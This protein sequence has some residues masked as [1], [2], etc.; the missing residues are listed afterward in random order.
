[1]RQTL[2]GDLGDSQ[3]TDLSAKTIQ[4]IRL[5]GVTAAVNALAIVRAKLAAARRDAA[6]A[7]ASVRRDAALC[8]HIAGHLLMM[9][10]E[11]AFTVH[12]VAHAPRGPLSD[13]SILA[14]AFSFL[15]HA[16]TAEPA[17]YLLE[18][19]FALGARTPSFSTLRWRGVDVPHILAGLGPSSLMPL[20]SALA[21]LTFNADVQEPTRTQCARSMLAYCR[22]SASHWGERIALRRAADDANAH[23]I[24][25]EEISTALGSLADGEQAGGERLQPRYVPSLSPELDENLHE[26]LVAGDGLLTYRLLQLATLPAPAGRAAAVLGRFD[27][28]GDRIE[29]ILLGGG[30]GGAAHGHAHGHAHGGAD[31]AD[32]G[33]EA[34]EG[35]GDSDDEDEGDEPDVEEEAFG[36][37]FEGSDGADPD[38]V[39]ATDDAGD[40]DVP[41]PLESRSAASPDVRATRAESSS[42]RAAAPAPASSYAS[43]S[44]PSRVSVPVTR[45]EVMT[46]TMAELQAQLVPPLDGCVTL[47]QPTQVLLAERLAALRTK[48]KAAPTSASAVPSNSDTYLPS[49][50]LGPLIRGSSFSLARDPGPLAAPRYV[51]ALSEPRDPAPAIL[52]PVHSLHLGIM[53]DSLDVNAVPAA[54]DELV[55][56]TDA[57]GTGTAEALLLARQ[58]AA[59]DAGPSLADAP[60]YALAGLRLGAAA[61]SD[62]GLVNRLSG[63]GVTMAPPF[64]ST[65][66]PA[67]PLDASRMLQL[68]QLVIERATGSSIGGPPIPAEVDAAMWAFS[69]SAVRAT[70]AGDVA[71]RPRFSWSHYDLP[72]CCYDVVA[73]RSVLVFEGDGDDASSAGLERAKAVPVAGAPA[74]RLPSCDSRARV[75][76]S[77]PRAPLQSSPPAIFTESDVAV[78]GG[79]AVRS[80][81][82]HSVTFSRTAA[83]ADAESAPAAAGLPP[84]QLL[85]DFPIVPSTARV[86]LVL[87]RLSSTQPN[88]VF[89]AST[90]LGGARRRQLQDYIAGC[91][92]LPGFARLVHGVDWLYDPGTSPP[93]RIHGPTCECRPET[94]NLI[95][96]LRAV[97]ALLDRECESLVQRWLPRRRLLTSAELQQ[98]Y[99]MH[100]PPGSVFAAADGRIFVDESALLL[101]G[102]RPSLYRPQ[103]TAVADTRAR[104]A[105]AANVWASVGVASSS[106][107]AV[108]DPAAMQSKPSHPQPS[109]RRVVIVD[110]VLCGRNAANVKPL[111]VEDIDSDDDGSSP[112][113]HGGDAHPTARTAGARP[114]APLS[115]AAMPACLARTAA[116]L[117]E[118][119]CDSAC[120]AG[121]Q[122][123]TRTL[124]RAAAAL[125]RAVRKAVASGLAL[126]R[127]LATERP[128]G[129]ISL[130]AA[131]LAVLPARS[132]FR[133]WF[134]SILSAFLRA[135]PLPV[136]RW[137]TAHGVIPAMARIL[138]EEHAAKAVP[139]LALLA[140]S[141]RGD[142]GGDAG[143]G[144]SAP[145]PVAAEDA[146]TA[147]TSE[148]EDGEESPSYDR[149]TCFDVLS[150]CLRGDMPAI[151]ELWAAESRLSAAA[152]A[153]AGGSLTWEPL[154]QASAATASPRDDDAAEEPLRSSLLLRLACDQL[155][156]SNMLWRSLI[157]CEDSCYGLCGVLPALE[158]RSG[159]EGAT[160]APIQPRHGSW[161]SLAGE[162][163][164]IVAGVAA[165]SV[166]AASLYDSMDR[167]TLAH[168]L[169]CFLR[170]LRVPLLYAL[171]G[172]VTVDTVGHDNLCN[173]NTALLFFVTAHR[174]GALPALV[175]QL[176]A[177]EDSLAPAAASAAAGRASPPLRLPSLKDPVSLAFLLAVPSISVTEATACPS[178]GGDACSTAAPV[179]APETSIPPSSHAVG[180]AAAAGA[181]STGSVLESFAHLL[182]FWLE[183]NS[184]RERDRRAMRSMTQYNYAE[185]RAVVRGLLGLPVVT[186]LSA[187]RVPLSVLAEPPT[188][189]FGLGADGTPAAYAPLVAAGAASA[190]RLRLSCAEFDAFSGLARAAACGDSPNGVPLDWLSPPPRL[191]QASI[192]A[193]ALQG[194]SVLSETDACAVYWRAA[195]LLPLRQAYRSA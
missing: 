180:A 33:V 112:T 9:L 49:R 153:P 97:H 34:V 59:L 45:S 77:P 131:L 171:M 89:F 113:S 86:A 51:P 177:H 136:R 20:T 194:G 101:D 104:A 21:G 138:V 188:A 3:D 152:L 129:V 18:E 39:D 117:R 54:E 160:E 72:R 102:V 100:G 64:D 147:S 148:C 174:H 128:R 150:E 82:H 13:E 66:S 116:P 14:S 67:P 71:L 35:G 94:Q 163:I 73:P 170:R 185:S 132:P 56:G 23:A 125:R 69:G 192:A 28:A 88:A 181:A 11:C 15:R 12:A 189:F 99:M 115:G 42:A 145:P 75:A 65:A 80:T 183:Y 151:D 52:T 1:M 62:W 139:S 142:K 32:E 127:E 187:A 134:G 41:L 91:G 126:P 146:S 16:A 26:L 179:L 81:E 178:A 123:Q 68:Q 191:V 10:R 53:R 63:T 166:S 17:R 193:A 143:V 85:G 27:S 182:T 175:A 190:E 36:D 105:A 22:S 98:A 78:P 137:L 31:D 168:P 30:G 121:G 119:V 110:P 90:L 186:P 165:P 44:P 37:L 106:T 87:H 7:S 2:S 144:S 130:I 29:D 149:Q 25:A 140:K 162:S 96:V 124:T 70:A 158:P 172:A 109:R 114:A 118:L 157:T 133:G 122:G 161:E 111:D 156:D 24:V 60:R 84:A 169:L 195:C 43:P 164:A 107:P 57:A 40:D 155:T 4:F 19:L 141:S 74:E 108:E 46:I 48:E 184:L 167:A 50:A 93:P 47:T 159:H 8:G 83:K 176:R 120:G 55:L 79:A 135:A 95:P 38:A 92:F 103:D 5:G 76:A 6:T 173:L 61:L 58:A 154:W